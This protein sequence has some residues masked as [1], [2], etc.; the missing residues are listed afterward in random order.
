MLSNWS[1]NDGRITWRCLSENDW[2]GYF[3]FAFLFLGKCAFCRPILN[4]RFH[5]RDIHFV[6]QWKVLVFSEGVIFTLFFR[7]HESYTSNDNRSCHVWKRAKCESLGTFYTELIACFVSP[8]THLFLSWSVMASAI[9][10]FFV[11]SLFT[12][13]LTRA[14]SAFVYFFSLT[15]R[16][17]F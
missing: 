15:R 16:G 1:N 9:L 14:L 8:W 7:W 6:L 2:W 11:H 4:N 17:R 3:V 5:P 12:A 13:I 10:H